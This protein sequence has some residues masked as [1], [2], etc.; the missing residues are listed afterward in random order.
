MNTTN[1]QANSSTVKN[2]APTAKDNIDN[3]K[4]QTV[5]LINFT[6]Y[7]QYF[8]VDDRE[9]CITLFRITQVLCFLLFFDTVF[10]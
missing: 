2:T 1:G 9:Y 10:L 7:P 6:F 8:V 4:S 5:S 3:T